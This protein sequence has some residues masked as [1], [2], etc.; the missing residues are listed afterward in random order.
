MSY[1]LNPDCRHQQNPTET[2]FCQNCGSRLLLQNRYRPLKLI[3]QGGFGRTFLAVDENEPSKPY[4]VIKQFLP[5]AQGIANTQKV[6][7]LFEQE[8]QRLEMLGKHP[9]I[10]QFLAHFEQDNRQYLVQEFIDGQNLAQALQAKGTFSERRIRDLLNS[11]LP[12][13]EFIHAYN[14]IHRDIKP[15][16]I[17]C[18]SDGQLV[19]VDFGAAKYATG[20]ALVRT[21]TVIGSAGYAAPEQAGGKAA[22]S[23]DLYSLG[24]TCLHLLTQAEPF[25]LYSFSEATWVWQDYLTHPISRRLRQVLDKMVKMATSQRYQ[26]ASEVLHALNS[27]P[28]PGTRTP[29]FTAKSAVQSPQ[30][31]SSRV[32]PTST[33]PMSN[34]RCVYSLERHAGS[35]RSLA[36]SPD[37]QLLASGS[38][39][40]T[41]KLWHLVTGEELFTLK[42]HTKAV[43][44]VAISADGEI[45]ASSSD[46]K[47]IKIWQLKTGRQ[48][49][50]ITLGNWFSGDSGCVYSVAISPNREIIASLSS[51]GTIKL[52]NLNTGREIRTIK[53]H[54]SWVQ[55]VAISPDGQIVAGG[56]DDSTILLWSL[57][58]GKLLHTFKGHSSWIQSVAF[59]PDGQI[60]A[61]GGED[62]TI[63]LWDLRIRRELCT[64]KGHTQSV[65][66][67]AFSAVGSGQGVGGDRTKTPLQELAFSKGDRT[68]EAILFILGDQFQ[69]KQ[70]L[71]VGKMLASSSDDRTIRLW[72]L[73]TE[74]ESCTLRGHPSWIHAVAFTPD[75]QTLVS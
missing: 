56:S 58:T 59:S 14:V 70:G 67:L 8:A 34:W 20:T 33:L 16:N 24:V 17:I 21:G 9:Q 54:N 12:V 60:L 61:S 37:G 32:T 74:Q 38:D 25:D 26:S 66:G 5:Q 71:G 72:D 73:S 53:A 19:L 15:E 1:C 48:L 69:K 51:G 44:S 47:T 3:G 7:E 63:K 4:C 10:P 23:S 75:G 65:Y 31:A 57:R 40:K 42:A 22:F 55:A 41:I 43:Y 18:R 64:L 49:G 27:P 39:D 52:W 30:T 28:N 29:R 68:T 46:D 36:I 2:T 45:L 62:A 50:T 35:I 13:I 11:L 6:A